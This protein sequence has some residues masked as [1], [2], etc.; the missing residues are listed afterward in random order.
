MLLLHFRRKVYT[1]KQAYNLLK[2]VRSKLMNTSFTIYYLVLNNSKNN[3]NEEV[4]MLAEV[5]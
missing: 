4:E 1:I 5:S 2:A 3:E